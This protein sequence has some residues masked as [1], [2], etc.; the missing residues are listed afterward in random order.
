MVENLVMVKGKKTKVIEI[1]QPPRPVVEIE[2]LGIEFHRALVAKL[3]E[4]E[5]IESLITAEVKHFSAVDV[6]ADS[7]RPST[8]VG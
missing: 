5:D 8:P 1:A 7:A 4:V 6:R 3:K 2:L